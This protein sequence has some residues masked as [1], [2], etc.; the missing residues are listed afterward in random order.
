[1]PKLAIWKYPIP[2]PPL[3]EVFSLPLPDRATILDV[4]V[5]RGEPVIWALA[6]T[7][8]DIVPRRFALYGTGHPVRDGMRYHGTFQLLG[9]DLVLHLF[10][11]Q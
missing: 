3:G 9:G 6:D 2:T 11:L 8:A 5:Q 10:E 1:M 4:Q 7:E